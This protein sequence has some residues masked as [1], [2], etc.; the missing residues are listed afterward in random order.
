MFVFGG[1]RK[2]GVILDDRSFISYRIR[3]NSS[4]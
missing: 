4:Q 2:W 1:Y 3:E